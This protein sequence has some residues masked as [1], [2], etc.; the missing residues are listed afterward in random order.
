MGHEHRYAASSS[1]SNQS[2]TWYDEEPRTFAFTLAAVTAS[3]PTRPFAAYKTPRSNDRRP[4][5]DLTSS[6]AKA[7]RKAR[8][9]PSDTGSAHQR[10]YGGQISHAES[11][12]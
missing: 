9:G 4:A 6:R 11:M 12:Q 5:S 8:P 1:S 2:Y 10:W 3:F 7:R